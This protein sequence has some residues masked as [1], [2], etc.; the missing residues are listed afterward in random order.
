MIFVCEIF[1]KKRDEKTIFVYFN[2]LGPTVTCVHKDAQKA[3]LMDREGG[4]HE[5]QGQVFFFNIKNV[6]P[7]FSVMKMHH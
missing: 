4:G 5:R 3:G 7:S 2:Y 6:L 1:V